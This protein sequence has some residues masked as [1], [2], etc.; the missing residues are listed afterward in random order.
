MLKQE[1]ID[2]KNSIGFIFD[3]F[4]R[5]AAQ[6]KMLDQFLN[7]KG[8]PVTKVIHLDTPELVVLNRIIKRGESNGRNDDN[9][10]AFKVRWSAY[11][12]QTVPAIDYF[13]GRGKVIK[14]NG[15]QTIDEVYAEIKKIIDEVN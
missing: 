5:T 14:V 11:Q 7:K 15:E 13:A 12:S 1:V 8:T 6:A 10:G 3:G 2:N 9:M 4:P